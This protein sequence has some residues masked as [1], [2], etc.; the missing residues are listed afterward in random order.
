[1]APMKITTFEELKDRHFGKIGT[2]ERDEMDALLKIRT[3][4]RQMLTFRYYFG[5]LKVSI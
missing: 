1:M 4:N 2:P 5:H 3:T